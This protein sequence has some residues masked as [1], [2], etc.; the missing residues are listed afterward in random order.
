MREAGDVEAAE[1]V[2]VDD[3]LECLGRHVE[4]LREEVAG[5]AR[6]QHVDRAEARRGLVQRGLHGIGLAHVGWLAL[7]LA[8][9]GLQCRDGRGHLVGR[10]ADD[11]EPG[12][13]LREG[14]G[15]AEVDA[16]G[17]AGDEDV[18]ALEWL[19][20]EVHAVQMYG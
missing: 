5:R 2:D 19:V 18:A 12:A 14:G 17:A 16:A 11:A 3:G 4:R 1:Q 7:R 6:D 20:R 13:G 15:D 10:A 8:A 9:E